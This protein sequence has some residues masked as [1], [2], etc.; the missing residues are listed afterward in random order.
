M[1]KG[2]S[3]YKKDFIDLSIFVNLASILSLSTKYFRTF[4]KI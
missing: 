2:V 1:F 4:S 3:D